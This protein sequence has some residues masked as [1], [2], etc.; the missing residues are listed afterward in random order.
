M[1]QKSF[2]IASL[3]T[4]ISG[5]TAA[6]SLKIMPW[7]SVV[8]AA[9]FVGVVKCTK[10]DYKP[11]FNEYRFFEG[12]ITQSWK[13]S[14]VGTVIMVCSGSA[15]PHFD[16]GGPKA[17]NGQSYF[18]F[19]I[20]RWT[21]GSDPPPKP[22]DYGLFHG[23]FIPLNASGPERLAIS[24]E[25]RT[26][27]AF[28]AAAEQFFAMS[29]HDR[30]YTVLR[31]QVEELTDKLIARKEPVPATLPGLEN[32]KTVDVLVD[33]LLSRM[34]RDGGQ[35]NSS[36]LTILE[37]GRAYTARALKQNR[38]TADVITPEKLD[39]LQRTF[40]LRAEQDRARD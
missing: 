2:I 13:G 9:H 28:K 4:F 33:V 19:G 12:E 5:T 35:D 1:I 39:R 37:S 24:G 14:P 38:K 15:D 11:R 40:N 26:W 30:E 21:A 17:E 22:A 6:S 8:D 29:P 25:F 23:G 16:F 3:L 20:K 10:S 7:Q 18:I 27:D 32:A 36:I 31:S 34:A